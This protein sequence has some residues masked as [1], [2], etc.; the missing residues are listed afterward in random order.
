MEKKSQPTSANKNQNSYEEEEIHRHQPSF[1][2]ASSRCP[3][4]HTSPLTFVAAAVAR[5]VAVEVAVALALA[6][7]ASPLVA[8][9]EAS[10]VL[11]GG[12]FSPPS[13]T[14][15]QPTNQALLPNLQVRSRSTSDSKKI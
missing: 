11:R 4:T 5:A 3:V 8:S 2:A 1:L 14:Q 10:L 6:D 12:W 9:W 15:T 13:S 7:A